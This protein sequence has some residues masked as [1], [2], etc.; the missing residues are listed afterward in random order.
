MSKSHQTL[1]HKELELQVKKA[2]FGESIKDAKELASWIVGSESKFDSPGIAIQALEFR[3]HKTS[4]P[5]IPIKKIIVTEELVKYQFFAG[6]VILPVKVVNTY[7]PNDNR[8]DFI[9]A[10]SAYDPSIIWDELKFTANIFKKCISAS[11]KFD[12]GRAIALGLDNYMLREYSDRFKVIFT[13]LLF[14][15]ESDQYL[16]S[17]LICNT[18]IGQ[19]NIFL[20]KII[21]FVDP[22]SLAYAL[23]LENNLSQ[24]ITRQSKEMVA[25]LLEKIS[26]NPF[27]VSIINEDIIKNPKNYLPLLKQMLFR[28]PLENYNLFISFFNHTD[29]IEALAKIDKPFIDALTKMYGLNNTPISRTDASNEF[30][31]LAEQSE[32]QNAYLEAA[33]YHLLSASS[34]Y[35]MVQADSK[36]YSPKDYYPLSIESLDQAHAML[37][38]DKNSPEHLHKLQT[39]DS[40]EV[41]LKPMKI[42]ESKAAEAKNVESIPP[43]ILKKYYL[44]LVHFYERETMQGRIQN[45]ITIG[46]KL[47]NIDLKGEFQLIAEL[48]KIIKNLFQ[49]QIKKDVRDQLIEL[50]S[51]LEKK[52]TDKFSKNSL[53]ELLVQLHHTRLSEE[54]E[55]NKDTIDRAIKFINQ[56]NK[57]NLSQDAKKKSLEILNRGAHLL[58]ETKATDA[59]E[60]YRGAAFFLKESKV[61]NEDALF[62]LAQNEEKH[63]A[64]RLEAVEHYLQLLKLESPLYSWLSVERLNNIKSMLPPTTELRKRIE[65]ELGTNVQDLKNNYDVIIAGQ[66]KLDSDLVK[67][68]KQNNLLAIYE[69]ANYHASKNNIRRSLSLYAKLLPLIINNPAKTGELFH[70]PPKLI[71]EMKEKAYR[72]ITKNLIE[73]KYQEYANELNELYF[74]LEKGKFNAAEKVKFP[75]DALKLADTLILQALTATSTTEAKAAANSTSASASDF[76]KTYI[77]GI[78][79]ALSLKKTWDTEQKTD[80]ETIRTLQ[81]FFAPAPNVPLAPAPSAPPAEVEGQPSAQQDSGSGALPHPV[82]SPPQSAPVPSAPPAEGTDQSQQEGRPPGGARPG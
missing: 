20:Q 17:Y 54:K 16:F 70:L 21:E 58:S 18:E 25:L 55:P 11:K 67:F 80:Q 77:L 74:K 65:K 26:K 36:N 29:A 61:I 42:P 63:D 79:E 81:T 12:L 9:T 27:A 52:A 45:I 1:P 2:L 82:A 48:N 6:E 69:L 73:G 5:P 44:T 57:E 64:N 78:A 46:K 3:N 66:K 50:I 47:L 39:L 37:N 76:R 28:Y 30:K 49:N 34:T 40:I 51:Q 38:K 13:H 19:N 60:V 41:L 7:G 22:I 62:K 8:T 32:K 15:Y 31:K 10:Y 43:E 71:L 23:I 33:Y 72:F 14:L 75:A 53:T 24:F 4:L 68:S 35:L 56:V 59:L